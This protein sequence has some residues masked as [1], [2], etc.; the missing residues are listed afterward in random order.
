MTSTTRSMQMHLLVQ[1]RLHMRLHMGT[2]RAI[3]STR[4]MPVEEE[5][6]QLAIT[7]RYRLARWQPRLCVYGLRTAKVP[8]KIYKKR[9]CSGQMN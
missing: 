1:L 4:L 8:R 6:V 5:R 3:R 2:T 9:S 7:E